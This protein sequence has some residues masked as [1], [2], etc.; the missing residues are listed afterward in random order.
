MPLNNLNSDQFL[1]TSFYN[2]RNNIFMELDMVFNIF[3]KVVDNISS[4]F[5]IILLIVLIIPLI[6]S[7]L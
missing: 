7:C 6:A 4:F 5:F 2:N 1:K 3:I